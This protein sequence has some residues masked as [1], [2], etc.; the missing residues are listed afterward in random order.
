MS[1]IDTG[2]GNPAGQ[3]AHLA[4]SKRATASA[5]ELCAS[6]HKDTTAKGR[7]R[8]S[9]GLNRLPNLNKL[10]RRSEMPRML[11]F[12]NC[13]GRCAPARLC[14]HPDEDRDWQR[15]QT[16]VPHTKQPW[17]GPPSP[18]RLHPCTVLSASR[19]WGQSRNVSD[20]R[21]LSDSRPSLW[22]E[23]SRAYRRGLVD[24]EITR[25]H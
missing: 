6:N 10:S 1:S 22:G 23:R 14:G 20:H 19:S 2:R 16:C 4:R 11:V 5:E 18:Q 24:Q 21:P 13:P 15:P 8:P 7:S 9:N 25:S 12:L 17:P 3:A